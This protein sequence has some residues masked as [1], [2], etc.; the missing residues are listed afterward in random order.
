M[1]FQATL[2]INISQ[3]MCLYKQSGIFERILLSQVIDIFFNT[4]KKGVF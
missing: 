2:I 3:I 4:G 1:N